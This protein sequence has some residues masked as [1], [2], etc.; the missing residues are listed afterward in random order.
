MKKTMFAVLAA[1]AIAFAAAPAS[2]AK[3]RG[4]GCDSATL[5]KAE[6]MVEA[7][8]DA[9]PSKQKGFKEMTDANEALV[10]GK[11]SEC[12][13]H[14]NAVMHMAPSKPAM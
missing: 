13:M 10:A 5:A 14:V 12:A 9:D 11:M 6:A 7:I 4:A 8:P 3:M 2:A 1:S